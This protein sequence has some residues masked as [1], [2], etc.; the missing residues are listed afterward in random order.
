MNSTLDDRVS[1]LEELGK[2]DPRTFRITDV[3]EILPSIAASEVDGLLTLLN[4]DP[5]R[6]ANWAI[7]TEFSFV[8]GMTSDGQ[9]VYRSKTGLYLRDTYDRVHDEITIRIGKLNEK[10]REQYEK[11]IFQTQGIESPFASLQEL[12]YKDGM[13]ANGILRTIK[14]MEKERLYLEGLKA[15]PPKARDYVDLTHK[16]L[17]NQSSQ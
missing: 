1:R 16:M 12:Q 8:V 9:I 3:A 11:P 5:N 13:H 10:S 4:S 7:S 2:K 17:P 6:P 14:A 15:N